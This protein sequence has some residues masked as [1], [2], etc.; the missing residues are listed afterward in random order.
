MS[1]ADDLQYVT[2]AEGKPTAVLVP[3]DLWNE[4]SSERETA[5]LL[6]NP[7]MRERLLAARA[8]SGGIPLDEA[9]A[10]LGV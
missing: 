1:V 9:L 6:R 2:D 10:R 4:I 3:I 7:A 5:Y 8:R